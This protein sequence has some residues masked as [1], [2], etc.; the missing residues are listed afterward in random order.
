MSVT[1]LPSPHFKSLRRPADLPTIGLHDLRHT[2][3]TILVV[4]RKHPKFV[5]ELLRH[6]GTN[7]TLDTYS[8][9]I[10]GDERRASGRCGRG[11]LQGYCY[12]TEAPSSG[13]ARS[14]YGGAWFIC[15]PSRMCPRTY[16]NTLKHECSFCGWLGSSPP[17]ILSARPR[18]LGG[19]STAWC[20][21]NQT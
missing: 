5:Q 3:A 16:P 20:S 9:V 6:R 2:F 19:E 1:N 12:V 11:S 10:E 21:H 17:Y 14:V 4:T 8:H 18:R 7:T 13:K 15:F